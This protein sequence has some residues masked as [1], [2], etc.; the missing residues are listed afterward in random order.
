[1]RQGWGDRSEGK[2]IEW[3]REVRGAVEIK[4]EKEI[5]MRRKKRKKKKKKKRRIG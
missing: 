4:R 5:K 2:G 1:M 3:I